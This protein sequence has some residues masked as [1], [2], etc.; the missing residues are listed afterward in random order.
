MFV[1]FKL[2][3]MS[4]SADMNVVQQSHVWY[5]GSTLLEEVTIGMEGGALSDSLALDHI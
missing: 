5:N 4:P 2:T 1:S 3:L